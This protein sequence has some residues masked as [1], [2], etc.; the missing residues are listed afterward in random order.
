MFGN[1]MTSKD[2]D[3]VALSS[4]L[5]ELMTKMA[6]SI[7]D[8]RGTA[9]RDVVRPAEVAADATAATDSAEVGG[10][11]IVGLE[12]VTRLWQ[13]VVGEAISDLTEVTRYR[14]GVLQVQVKAA[15]LLAE[16]RAFAK[17]DL[18]QGLHDSGL[19]GI[20]DIRFKG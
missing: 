18:L 8:Q 1:E 17:G 16:L 15:P 5:K 11:P 9:S 3:P 14:G 12:E 6:P 4:L 2:R 19:V 10:S 13:G 7:A 20:H